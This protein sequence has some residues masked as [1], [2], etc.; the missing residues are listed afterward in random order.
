MGLFQY[1]T[2]TFFLESKM[3]KKVFRDYET[4]SHRKWYGKKNVIKTFRIKPLSC[5]Q[6]LIRNGVHIEHSLLNAFIVAWNLEEQLKMEKTLVYLVGHAWKR[7]YITFS[8]SV[9]LFPNR[10]K[11]LH[12]KQLR[13]F[14]LVLKILFHCWKSRGNGCIIDD[15]Q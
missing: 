10:R 14:N 15:Y 12:L 8:V 7:W 3:T 4:Q 2:F 5:S 9:T 11:Y 6:R 1:E 13:D